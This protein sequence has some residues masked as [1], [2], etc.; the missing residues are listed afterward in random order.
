MS[1]NLTLAEY[2]SAEEKSAVTHELFLVLGS[3]FLI[4]LSAQIAVGWPVPVTG[5]TF[6]ILLIAAI[7]G[8]KRASL[9]VFAY[10]CEGLI[11]LPVFAQFKAGIPALLGSTGGYIL[12]FLAAAFVV[13]FLAE[14][15]RDGSNIKIFFAMLA[16][17][18]VI[19]TLGIL[20]LG[21]VLK[22]ANF[23]TVLKAGLFP[24][25]PYEIIKIALALTIV[26][27][28]KPI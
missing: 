24:F 3:S 7:L 6:S 15:I 5:Q 27:I 20:W 14:R 21:I 12:G 22:G 8:S 4:A 13:G 1:F 10:I 17:L 23:L 18:I 19:Y 9:A 28:M 11:G 2:A 26:R 16:G 25:I